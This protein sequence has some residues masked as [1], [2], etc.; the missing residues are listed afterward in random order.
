MHISLSEIELT[1]FLVALVLLV[2]SAHTVGYLFQKIQFPRVI[3]EIMGG[4]ILGPSLLGHFFPEMYTWIFKAFESEG[5]LLAG[6]YWV[7]LILLMF[8]SGFEIKSS[9]N[10]DDKKIITA[11]LL[12]GTLFPFL[13]GWGVPHIYD[14][15]P[16]L[17]SRNNALALRIVM[18]I[19]IAIT[20]I[21]VISKIFIDL[22]IMKTRFAKIVIATAT[23]EDVILWV[24]LAIATGLVS[25]E[26]A[27]IET[28]GKNVSI[29]ILFLIFGLAVLPKLFALITQWQL[30]YIAKSSLLGYT[31]LIGLALTAVASFLKVNA[32][33]GALLAGI[34]IGQQSQNQ[35]GPTKLAIK[36]FS[37]AFFIPIY[38]AI[39]GLKIDLIHHFNPL[40]FVG[41][42]IFA[43]ICK[44]LGTLIA[45]KLVTKNWLSSINLSIAMNAR[46]GPGIILAT[47]AYD[48]GIISEMFFSTL[49]LTAIVTSLLAGYW[50]LFV[51]SKKWQLLA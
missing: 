21:P 4:L 39:V 32:I 1:H 30:N 44:I 49:V 26:A 27:S 37:L 22:N 20:S 14:I 5:K 17:G 43:V 41:F 13:A 25:G 34:V 15:S 50:F 28:I 48:L 2:G 33:F 6:I 46:G 19:A 16:L 45:A 47:V 36:Q 8:I 29:T 35:L 9:F 11:I 12:G 23:I 51:L 18:S 3:G 7:G 38:F 31:I 24:A 42:L 40:F 10:K